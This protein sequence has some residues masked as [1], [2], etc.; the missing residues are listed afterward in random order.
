MA[1][2][3]LLFLSGTAGFK[4]ILFINWWT[5]NLVFQFLK[6]NL[7]VNAIFDKSKPFKTLYEKLITNYGRAGAFKFTIFSGKQV[8]V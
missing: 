7:F 8:P 4:P 1:S 6:L 3:I 2:H 5:I